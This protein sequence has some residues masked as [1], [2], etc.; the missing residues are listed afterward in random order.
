MPPRITTEEMLKRLG[1]GQSIAAVCNAA[2]I[3]RQAFDMWW[4]AETESRVPRAD[5]VRQAGVHRTASIE[6]DERGIP[7]VL[8]DNDDDLF[9]AFGYALAQDRLFQLDYLRRK[10]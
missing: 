2:G 5:G 1:D 3:S 7:H 9:F 10:A 6:R 4:T 8:A